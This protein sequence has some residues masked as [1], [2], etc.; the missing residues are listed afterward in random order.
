MSRQVNASIRK[1]NHDVITAVPVILHNRIYQSEG[2]DAAKRTK[3]HESD[4]FAMIDDPKPTDD[5]EK[6]HEDGREDGYER[7]R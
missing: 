4:T 3:C 6:D 1:V 2:S 7:C 5:P